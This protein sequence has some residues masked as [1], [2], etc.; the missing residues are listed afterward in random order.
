MGGESMKAKLAFISGS[1][2]SIRLL[3]AVLGVARSWFHDWQAGDQA[4]TA[5]NRVEVDLVG[6]I[7]GIFQHSGQR[8]G[9]PRVHA[10]LRARGI[11]VARKRVARLMKEN[12][13]PRR[14]KRPPIT[15]GTATVLLRTCSSAPS[16]PIARTPSGSQTLRMWRLMRAGCTWPPSRTWRPARSSAGA[17]P[18]I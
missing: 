2:Y 8:Y 17:W 10:E 9:A 13:M 12:G 3:C 14:K 1:T 16:R 6:Q 18:T 15:A 5:E 4:R 11:R 7:R